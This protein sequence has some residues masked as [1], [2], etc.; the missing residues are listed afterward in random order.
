MQEST[1][2][3]KKLNTETLLY[4]TLKHDWSRTIFDDFSAKE[5]LK[6]ELIL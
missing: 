4:H 3:Q 2:V 1:S 6:H 5:I